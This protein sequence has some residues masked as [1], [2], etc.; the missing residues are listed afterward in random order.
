[1]SETYLK[2]LNKLPKTMASLLEGE[3]DAVACLANASALIFDVVP[4]INWAGFYF[5]KDGEL[6]LG[7]FQGKPACVRL[8]IGKGVCGTAVERNETVV[9]KD[10]HEFAGHIACDSASQSEI[11][12]PLHDKDGK[13]WGV[14]DIDSPIVNRFEGIKD[15][16]VETAKEIEKALNA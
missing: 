4:D 12:V 5:V 7:P 6:V 1:M 3:T 16:I 2:D 10:V 9:V 11:V 15:V 14:L 13:T 8:K